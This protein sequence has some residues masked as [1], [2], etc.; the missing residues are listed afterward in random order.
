MDKDDRTGAVDGL[1]EL[2]LQF[3]QLLPYQVF[4]PIEILNESYANYGT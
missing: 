1:P 2:R 3:N 4:H